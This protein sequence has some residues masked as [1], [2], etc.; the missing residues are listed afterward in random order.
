MAGRKGSVIADVQ[1]R[2]EA[3]AME[4]LSLLEKAIKTGRCAELEVD[5]NFFEILLPNLSKFEV[6]IK[7]VFNL[8]PYCF[9]LCLCR[10]FR[11][12]FSHLSSRVGLTIFQFKV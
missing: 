9:C 5:N 12:L 6:K 2:F 1:L 11:L 8:I 4:P 10:F 3:S 7:V